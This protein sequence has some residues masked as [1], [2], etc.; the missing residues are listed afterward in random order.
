VQR[1]EQLRVEEIDSS[2]QTAQT[3]CY[4]C[5]L[6]DF[7][8]S[9]IL[10]QHEESRSGVAHQGAGFVAPGL[11]TSVCM[12]SYMVCVCVCVCVGVCV[13]VCV[14]RIAHAHSL[15]STYFTL[16][17]EL[18]VLACLWLGPRAVMS[19]NPGRVCLLRKQETESV[20]FAH[21]VPL[22]PRCAEVKKGRVSTMASDIYSAGK[23]LDE[24]LYV[25][26]C[27]PTS[28]VR[29]CARQDAV[30]QCRLCSSF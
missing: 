29:A 30:G 4:T 14:W 1:E 20:A 13:C 19:A 25:F 21:C 17:K 11:T 7:G 15:L 8:H 6:G 18:L 2:A 22:G 9:Y 5:A 12:F 3:V 16:H 24:L 10:S 26:P 23:I 28:L 27:F